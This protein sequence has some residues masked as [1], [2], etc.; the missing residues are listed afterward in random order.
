MYHSWLARRSVCSPG[1]VS[2][3]FWLPEHICAVALENL[4]VEKAFTVLS[5]Q[6]PPL[7]TYQAGKL[8]EVTP[9]PELKA[10]TGVYR[11][12]VTRAAELQ[13]HRAFSAALEK[14]LLDC[15]IQHNILLI[16]PEA[17]FIHRTIILQVQ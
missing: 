11:R 9:F 13:M 5:R 8:P 17:F 3:F 12:Q 1:N 16:F 2:Y 14:Q 6:I 4:S 7:V 15:G 10:H